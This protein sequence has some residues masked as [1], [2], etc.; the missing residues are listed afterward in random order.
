MQ[1]LQVEKWRVECAGVWNEEMKELIGV[2]VVNGGAERSMPCDR[3]STTSGASP[4]HFVHCEAKRY[5]NGIDF[6]L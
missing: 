6:N 3:D 5:I 2:K 4:L 1:W